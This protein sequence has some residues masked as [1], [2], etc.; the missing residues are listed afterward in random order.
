MGLRSGS[1]RQRRAIG[2]NDRRDPNQQNNAITT[3]KLTYACARTAFTNTVPALPAPSSPRI[4]AFEKE[5]KK[6]RGEK[7]R[8]EPVAVGASGVGSA[9]E[10]RISVRASRGEG[11][12]NRARRALRDEAR[13]EAQAEA[14][15]QSTEQQLSGARGCGGAVQSAVPSGNSAH[16]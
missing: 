3:S 15:A 4:F 2:P 7:K 9:S 14:E 11:R 5:R 10:Q 1:E 13:D 12:G 8:R 16:D 6:R